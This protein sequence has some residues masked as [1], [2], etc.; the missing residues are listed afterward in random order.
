MNEDDVKRD[1]QRIEL[2]GELRGEVM[3]FQPMLIREM[4]KGGMQVETAFPLQL[5]SLHE[6]RLTLA[7]G[8]SVVVKGR[9]AHSHISDVDQ[10][11]IRYRSGIEFV[12]PPEHVAEVIAQF[13]EMLR[14]HR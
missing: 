11:V 14:Q 2:L 13:V 5:D 9:I 4:S 10:D 12:E 8:Q 3:V 7:G 1:T 6:F